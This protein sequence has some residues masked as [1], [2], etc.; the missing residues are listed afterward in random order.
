M[1][2]TIEATNLKLYYLFYANPSM[3]KQSIDNLVRNT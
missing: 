1:V 2:L 3:S